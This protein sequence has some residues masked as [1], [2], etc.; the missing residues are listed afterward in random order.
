M[1][2]DNTGA[3]LGYTGVDGIGIVPFRGPS[4]TNLLE[5][6]REFNTIFSKIHAAVEHAVAKVK[7]WRTLSR[8]DGR[9]RCPT[10]N[11]ESMSVAVAGVIFLRGIQ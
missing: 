3:D 2:A 11:F 7:T 6:Q 4:G 8:E 1:A 9:Y 10:D 5:W